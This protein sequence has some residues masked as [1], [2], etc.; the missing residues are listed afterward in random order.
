MSHT[1]R[2]TIVLIAALILVLATIAYWTFAGQ[3]TA[4]TLKYVD[5][6]EEVNQEIADRTPG[7]NRAD[8]LGL[9]RSFYR[10][11]IVMGTPYTLY[12]DKVWY[13]S[14]QIY[15][16]YHVEY[17]SEESIT[18][19][20]LP[21]LQFQVTAPDSEGQLWEE[22]SFAKKWPVS[23][24]IVYNNAFYHRLSV[25]PLKNQDLKLISKIDEIALQQIE[26][27]IGDETYSLPDVYLPIDFN[28][29]NERLTKITFAERIEL[30]GHTA[31]L[32][33]L[34]LGIAENSLT[35]RVLTDE[36]VQP[37]EW[38]GRV[39]IDEEVERPF[40][41]A[42][43]N[44]LGD[45]R[46]RF[47]FDPFDHVPEKIEFEIEK[48]AWVGKEQIT[49]RTGVSMW[50]DDG[51]ASSSKQKVHPIGEMIDHIHGTDILFDEWV[52][53]E[54]GLQFQFRYDVP[55]KKGSSIRLAPRLMQDE[56]WIERIPWNANTVLTVLDNQGRRLEVFDRFIEGEE[57]GASLSWDDVKRADWIEF[58][59]ERLVHEVDGNWQFSWN[60]QVEQIQDE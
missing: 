43:L 27:T 29:A 56:D 26:L 45:N 1:L 44:A 32:E 31:V 51:N 17:D 19:D 49:Y 39:I 28:A 54:E 16:F 4:D 9:T 22:V 55:K 57:F 18:I 13:N 6:M 35:F 52:E 20:N 46:Y 48:V 59:I 25:Q 50:L 42:R 36:D 58:K 34:E 30:G 33:T 3:A 41:R 12:F 2:V 11:R 23:E 47:E 7:L 53:T 38:T 37:L 21:Y 14:E 8:E 40:I 24:G 60:Q 10:K 5:D 15:V